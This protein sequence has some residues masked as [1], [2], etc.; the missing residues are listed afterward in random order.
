M[1]KLMF[2]VAAAVASLTATAQ[3]AKEINAQVDAAMKVVSSEQGNYDKYKVKLL[4][5]Y[6]AATYFDACVEAINAA[7]ACEEVDKQPNEKGK[8]SP[9]FRKKNQTRLN[10]LR[11]E[12]VEG[13]L[14]AYNTKEYA[15][16]S[17]YFGAFVDS[18]AS[19][20]YEGFDFS[21]ETSYG[22]IAYY[23]ALA[24]FFAKEYDK[25]ISR[26]EIAL[27]TNDPE[28]PNFRDDAINVL[29][30]SNEEL[31]KA[32]NGTQDAFMAKVKGL[33]QQYPENPAI[34]SK[35][36]SLYQEAGD[37]AGADKVIEE[38]LQANPTDYMALAIQ[39]QNA[40]NANDLVKA[41]ESYKRAIDAK[42]DFLAVKL[43]LAIC[44]LN[45]AADAID[46]NTNNM[47]VIAANAKGGII[48]DL[49]A[50]KKYF[51]ELQAADPN[52]EQ[53]SWKF[54][55]DRVNYALENLK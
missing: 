16:A 19:S 17:K 23:G 21:A 24:A 2:L 43:N 49:N 8:V 25:A 53:V 45:K 4:P 41:I 31:V 44:Y 54:N 42:P 14:N 9:K 28:L 20:L 51:E 22:Q 32:G 10:P 35:L 46:Q 48:E 33:S 27:G 12:L 47:G 39:G 34:F 52:E 37:N 30:S 50:S 15:A 18:R 55:Y 40:Q 26:A 29:I 7:L 5:D 36:V 13:G 6:N 38:R 11:I 3:T 1:K